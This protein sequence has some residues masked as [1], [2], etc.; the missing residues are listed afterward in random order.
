MLAGSVDGVHAAIDTKGQGALADDADFKAA[1][2]QVDHD[3]VALTLTRTRPYIDVVTC[4]QVVEGQQVPKQLPGELRGAGADVTGTAS[5]YRDL[6]RLT[7]GFQPGNLI[8]IAARP[9]MGKSA[10]V[11]NMAENVALNK[12][13]PRP[14]A[15]PPG[16]SRVR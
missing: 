4:G 11:T 3:Y 2:A 9:A 16:R 13:R 8:I 10:L 12:E 15:L 5:G 1:F 14:V 7:S 6:D